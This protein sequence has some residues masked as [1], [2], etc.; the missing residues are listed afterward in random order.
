MTEM[1]MPRS[2]Y[3]DRP[4]WAAIG[5]DWEKT[6]YLV[7]IALAFITRFYNLGERV[8]SHDESLH[9]FYS[10]ELS[11]GKGFAHTPLMHGT[12]QFHALALSYTI[13]G[14]SDFTA[15]IPAALCGVAAV[16]IMYFYRRW[17]GR[18]GALLAALFFLISPYLLYYTRYSREDPYTL[19][20]QLVMGVALFGYID[21]KGDKYLYL[22]AAAFSLFSATKENSFFNAAMWLVFTGLIYLQNMFTSEWPMPEFKRFF[23]VSLMGSVLAGIIAG[24]LY[25]YGRYS[26][27][28]KE[29][30]PVVVQGDVATSTA[31][32]PYLSAMS[33]ALVALALF[34]VVAALLSV[35]AFREK[36]REFP[37]F[38]M[39]IVL[40]SFVF[41]QLAALPVKMFL[42]SDPLDYSSQGLLRTGLIL[43]PMFLISAAMGLLWDWKRWLI[44]AGIFYGLYIPLFTT[45]FTN[46]GGFFTGIVGSLGY[47]LDQQDVQRGSQPWYFYLLVQVP[48]Y[49]FLPAIGTLL[50]VGLGAWRWIMAVD[51]PDEETDEGLK[52]APLVS[53]EY[54][55]PVIWFLLFWIILAFGAYSY[56][57]EKMPWLTVHMT[58]P[59]V[60]AAGWSFGLIID[61]IDW[62]NFRDNAGW[63]ALGVIPLTL[64]AVV[65]AVYRLGFS[66]APP[67]QGNELPQLQATLS[68]VFPLLVAGAGLVAVYVISLRLGWRQ[69]GVLTVGL[70]GAGL[71]F[72]TAR[73][74]F[75]ANYINFD[76][77][78]EFINYASGAPG[79]KVV[80]AQVEEISKR[81]T[82]GLGIRV[83]Y[84]DD[85]SWPVTW[86]MRDFTG[87][88]Y[89]GASPSRDTFK[90]TPLIIAGD[91]NWAKV[92]P[93]LGNRYYTFEYIRMW[94]PMQE[95]FNLDKDPNVDPNGPPQGRDRIWNAIKDPAYRE[96]IF[97]IWFFRD[98][99]KYGELTNVD[100]SLSHWPVSDRM[101]FYVRKDIAAQLWPLGVGP[102]V[103]EA[104]IE[105]PYE[106]NKLLLT[107][108]TVWGTQGAGDGQFTNPRAVAI[109]PDGS[110][111]VADTRGNRIEKFT[112]DGQFVTAWGSFGNL[113]AQTDFDGTFNEIWGLAVDSEG[114]VYASD[115]WNHRIQKFT[116]DGEFVAKWGVF[117]LTDSG[118]S[119]MWGPRGIAVD[120]DSNVYVADTGNK[121]ILVFDSN[122]NPI[123]EIG[124][125]GAL[126]GQLDEP[127]SV[128]VA[129]DGRVFVADTWN[130]RVQV[131]TNEGAFLGKW[132]I[133][134]WLSQTLD[135]KPYITVDNLNRVYVSD[136]EAY[137]VIVFSDNGLFQYTF[138]DF[139]EDA[140]TFGLPAGLAV[141]NGSLFVVDT[142]NN[143]VMRFVV[144]SGT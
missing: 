97:H 37:A 113:E 103:A 49:E 53:K 79:V 100:Y 65:Y 121:R 143:R 25:W 46:G 111:Y 27:W 32:N 48:I 2:N 102:A 16:G 91:N 101:R 68:F 142:N 95:Y 15:R 110:I 99:K 116:A 126:D 8:I 80:M 55:F 18:T 90:D 87:Q 92:E 30:A 74:A 51:V 58:L 118:L 64:Y 5:L 86:Y 67:F 136:P 31:N 105:D 13:F 42:N 134:G 24:F 77:Q 29:N 81:T 82:D 62:T 141:R 108:D 11:K 38:G 20:W 109:G 124:S 63:I 34:L 137:R 104:S 35:L 60:L 14:A 112:A 19:V 61:A 117:G 28:A 33:Y 88:I 40:F 45:M 131:F 122:G 36:I 4:L 44:C 43:V 140:T 72:L 69:I 10:W 7:L 22:M 96:A 12:L 84:D 107:A 56:A 115:T 23:G 52:Q 9:T 41:P 125:G 128:A 78:T 54:K 1:T 21:T 144:D 47:W 3:L 130:Q 139:G 26:T 133:A 66:G 89:Y 132:E 50:A 71:V 135:N 17:L 85:V 129:E 75:Y 57:G 83:A 39:L 106:K 127:T 123:R 70:F 76:N 119:A 93:L 98:Y 114:F 73:A 6:L 59:M 120:K 94:W 138:G